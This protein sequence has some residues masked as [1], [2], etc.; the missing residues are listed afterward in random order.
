[1]GK[2]TK[3]RMDIYVYVWNITYSAVPL[4]LTVLQI[5]CISKQFLKIRK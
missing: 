3:K 2:E 1:M 4:K 5:N